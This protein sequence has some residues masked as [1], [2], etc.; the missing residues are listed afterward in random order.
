MVN[1]N[2]SLITAGKWKCYVCRPII[3]KE[4]VENCNKVM[5][6]IEKEEQKERAREERQR[7]REKQAAMK[8]K[9]KDENKEKTKPEKDNEKKRDSKSSTP[10]RSSLKAPVPKASVPII[11]KDTDKKINS[12]KPN[13]A[14][15]SSEPIVIPDSSSNR[16]TEVI[17]VGP[18]P[19]QAVTTPYANTT[20]PLKA[21]NN[22]SA[23]RMMPKQFQ[24]N[25]NSI[26]SPNMT[27]LLN[28]GLAPKPPIND[29]TAL[30]QA[31]YPY[32]VDS[33]V[34][35]LIAATQSMSLTLNGIKT[36]LAIARL[37][38]NNLFNARSSGASNLK[39]GLH[40]FLNSIREIFNVQFVAVAG[41][42]QPPPTT[43]PG[44]VTIN[45]K[46]VGIN[47]KE[48]L[49]PLSSTPVKNEDKKEPLNVSDIPILIDESPMKK[50]A[51][52]PVIIDKEGDSG[53]QKS[54]S[55]DDGC[56]VVTYSS[57]HEEG[58]QVNGVDSDSVME[59][60]G[61][62]DGEEAEDGE[63]DENEEVDEETQ[64][65]IE[66]KQRRVKEIAAESENVAA[67]LEILKEMADELTQ[68]L[69][70][71]DDDDNGDE[72]EEVED[73][74]VRDEESDKEVADKNTSSQEV[75]EADKNPCKSTADT[76]SS[77]SRPL[78]STR[79][80]TELKQGKNKNED[81]EIEEESEK[82]PDRDRKELK[83]VSRQKASEKQNKA[84]N[85]DKSPSKVEP[86]S[87]R[88]RS[89]RDDEDED[90]NSKTDARSSR[91]KSKKE[92]EEL[93][94]SKSKTS[95]LEADDSSE[96]VT[97]TTKSKKEV[98]E[99][100][101]E[102][103]KSESKSTK[104]KKEDSEKYKELS[105]SESKASK[106]KKENIVEKVEEKSDSKT[107]KDE[108]G[109]E[110]KGKI[111]VTD[112]VTDEETGDEET[113]KDKEDKGI[114]N[115]TIHQPID[116]VL[117]Y[118]VLQTFHRKND[119][120]K[121]LNPEGPFGSYLC[122]ITLP[123][124]LNACQFLFCRTKKVNRIFYWVKKHLIFLSFLQCI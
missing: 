45:G 91:S 44:V 102:T 68:V 43:S 120:S 94:K 110:K 98:T 5:A 78:R 103:T 84:D 112:I 89:K 80:S 25:T 123:V 62:D 116:K 122:D 21:S 75:T 118:S 19:K 69:G 61:D 22:P 42:P 59:V 34:E 74:D 99:K 87:S 96:K 95:K 52:E 92:E 85:T 26:S 12:S 6:C 119:N 56:V 72:N 39:T 13:S 1:P 9:P 54:E 50:S 29:L 106:S 41:T 28:R 79:S 70:N 65:A 100:E 107:K 105:K 35:K 11:I 51:S 121:S 66:E 124:F 117:F 3:L 46:P 55:K 15:I 33:A 64:K 14:G 63:V 24:N 20:F 97:E 67:Q 38:N 82:M 73:S 81:K 101:K 27:S 10:T 4:L 114:F 17:L 49:Q 57:K 113:P 115:C 60:D 31:I 77:Q 40:I 58:K 16:T 104:S 18:K 83:E 76:E 30:S 36:D 23:I 93:S 88:S 86:R 2:F 47:L 8:N 7:E 37:T 109:K 53:A 48:T 71:D 90:E 32:H 108:K 111:K